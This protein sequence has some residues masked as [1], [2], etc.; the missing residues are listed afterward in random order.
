MK[1]IGSVLVLVLMVALIAAGCVGKEPTLISVDWQNN[2]FTV[3]E[4]NVSNTYQFPTG[5]FIAEG[6]SFPQA[7]V[8]SEISGYNIAV[9]NEQFC[10][11]ALDGGGIDLKLN[12]VRRPDGGCID[13]PKEP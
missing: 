5:T 4:G 9:D 8:Y 2:T 10:V 7:N 1:K 6:I 12:G 3:S 13:R 11:F